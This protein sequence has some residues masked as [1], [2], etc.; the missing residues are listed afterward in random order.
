M[1]EFRFRAK[2]GQ[3]DMICR[4]L[5]QHVAKPKVGLRDGVI[6]ITVGI[7]EGIT[8]NSIDRMLFANSVPGA[9]NRTNKFRVVKGDKYDV[10]Y[11]RHVE[12]GKTFFWVTREGKFLGKYRRVFVETGC[13][14]CSGYYDLEETN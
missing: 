2:Q 6:T 4:L 1:R 14:C 9:V 10:M 11:N 12:T 7:P 3:A 5:T 13:T 8:K